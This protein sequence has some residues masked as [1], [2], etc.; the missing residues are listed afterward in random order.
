MTS[1][2]IAIVGGGNMGF[3]LAQSYLNQNPDATVIVSDPVQSQLDRYEGT[4]IR[5]TSNNQQA[6]QNADLVI[7]AVK[8]Q[9]MCEVATELK[10]SLSN[11]LIVSI[12]AGI[13]L[14]S[15]EEWLGSTLPIIRCMPNTPVM[16]GEGMFG[17][18]ANGNVEAEHREEIESVFRSAGSLL[19]FDSD[20]EIDAVTALSGSGPA[21]FFRFTEAL[22]EAG[23]E[24]GLSTD[25]A[26]ELAI[27]TCIGAAKMLRNEDHSPTQLRE[28][29]TSKGGTTEAALNAMREENV[30]EAIIRAV[31]AAFERSIELSKS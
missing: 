1:E 19:W 12:A 21:Y 28:N 17:M 10:D 24:I 7:L 31:H 9:V 16:V 6:V 3:A 4:S 14:S 25:A 30:P 13:P 23:Q 15:L 26:K 29:V 5:T 8:P 11:Q 22:I 2:T 18:L 27:Q 20:R